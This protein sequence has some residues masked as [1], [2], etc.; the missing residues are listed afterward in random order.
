MNVDGRMVELVSRKTDDELERQ[1]AKKRWYETLSDFG[2]TVELSLV[3]LGRGQDSATYKGYVEVKR[4]GST[5][6]I[7]ITGGCGA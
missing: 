4:R 7:P 3:E 6:R 5:M 2:L 1:L